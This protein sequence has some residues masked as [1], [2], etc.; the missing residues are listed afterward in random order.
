[1]KI[2]KTA[3]PFIL[4]VALFVIGGLGIASS[5][6][7]GE[8]SSLEFSLKSIGYGTI[9][10]VLILPSLAAFFGGFFLVIAQTGKL[11]ELFGLWE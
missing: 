3:L 6:A 7:L 8:Q 2:V 9:A 4:G 1:M 11:L 10:A 5:F